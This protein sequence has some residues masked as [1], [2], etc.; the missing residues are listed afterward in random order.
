MSAA[1]CTA[2]IL[3]DG[4]DAN[5]ENINHNIQVLKNAQLN[6]IYC[7]LTSPE[8]QDHEKINCPTL[9]DPKHIGSFKAL[10][11]T[12][13]Y[14][15]TNHISCDNGLLVVYG[16]TFLSNRTINRIFQISTISK[17]NSSI[18]S[19]VSVRMTKG[20]QR[21]RFN[22]NPDG[23]LTK[24]IHASRG[25]EACGLIYLTPAALKLMHS[26]CGK[27][28]SD[29]FSWLILQKHKIYG[30]IDGCCGDPYKV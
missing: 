16:H 6:N 22:L 21:L 4:I 26:C 7:C 29:F 11:K 3:W 1:N 12:L 18:T 17:T 24:P 10:I 20:K 13:N 23:T 30:I 2:I 28:M 27:T 19:F 9:I 25:H 15:T 5:I 8:N 14:F